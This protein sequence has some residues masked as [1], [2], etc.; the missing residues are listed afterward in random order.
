[1]TEETQA[2]DYGELRL[3]RVSKDLANLELSQEYLEIFEANSS[4]HLPYHGNRHQ[5]AVAILANR[6]AGYYALRTIERQSIVL[7]A[8]FHDSGYSLDRSEGANIAAAQ[9]EAQVAVERLNPELWPKVQR[10]IAATEMPHGKP[11]SLPA[12]IIQDADLLMVTQPDFDDF[13]AGL[14]LENPGMTPDP[15]FPGLDGLNT[16]WGKEIY[17]TAI[18]IRKSGRSILNP[19]EAIFVGNTHHKQT[20]SSRGFLVDESLAE[21]LEGLWAEGFETLFSCSGD[22]HSISPGWD[23]PMRGYIAFPQPDEEHGLR[24]EAAARR[25]GSE[26]EFYE[27]GEKIVV[28]VRFNSSQA[29]RF[30]L[31]LLQH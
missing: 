12:A 30:F 2:V 20:L 22:I 26:L 5:L 13:L 9:F 3:R 27:S 21:G 7:A 10:L 15:S 25:I 31:Q 29:D 24:L 23:E 8:L 4:R 1:V 18:E 17:T 16:P 6:G 14:A 28:V 11:R 19:A